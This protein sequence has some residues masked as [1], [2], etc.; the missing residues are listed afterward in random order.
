MLD[1]NALVEGA[2]AGNGIRDALRFVKR[3]KI[4]ILAP[5]VLFAGTAWVIASVMPPRFAA[6]SA[7]TLNVS[8]VQVVDREVVSRLPLESSTLKSEIDVIRSRSLNDEVAVKLGLATDPVAVREASAWLKPWPYAARRVWNALHRHFPE[9]IG[10]DLAFGDTEFVPSR[11]QLT[12]WLIDNLNVSNDGRSLTIVVSFTSESPELAA[13]ISNAVAQAYLDD[14]VLVKNRAT[15][16]AT[17][18][19]GGA[20]AKIRQQLEA[21]EAAVDDFRRKFGLL[22]VKGETIPATR[23]AEMNAQL[24][25]ARAERT[26]AELKLQGARD[27]GPET[28]PDVCSPKFRRFASYSRSLNSFSHPYSLSGAAG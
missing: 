4:A 19:L 28:I 7:L 22:Q 3:H 9:F 12:D 11:A 2:P 26:R 1:S 16:K 25:N 5:A 18:W 10:E 13:R 24:A 6:I 27:S 17:D 14:Q 15:M 8:K 21:S 20:V 23:L